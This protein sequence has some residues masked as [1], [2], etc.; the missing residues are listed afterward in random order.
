MDKLIALLRDLLPLEIA[1]LIVI[2]IYFL[3]LFKELATDFNKIAQQQAEYMRLRVESVDKT[4]SIFERTVEHQE[5]DLRRLY[6][7]NDK[8][9]EQLEIKKEEGIERL[10]AQLN[11]VVESLEQ[12]RQEKLSKEEVDRLKGDLE[13]AKR[14]TSAKYSLMIESLSS[15]EKE[16]V[17]IGKGLQ[18]VFVVMPYTKDAAE[19]YEF[20]K[21]T[22]T[23][24]L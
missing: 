3:K 10:D 1:A 9:K 21:N 5:K 19:R 6:E 7:L 11:D 23:S 17:K 15:Q 2:F 8:L 16:D 12:I 18:K 22:V 14:D 24:A 20:I 4:T 13:V